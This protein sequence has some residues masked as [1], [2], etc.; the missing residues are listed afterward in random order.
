[1]T[2]KLCTRKACVSAASRTKP[3][4]RQA[5][6]IQ[7]PRVSEELLQSLYARQGPF[8]QLQED[9]WLHLIRISASN[10]RLVTEYEYHDSPDLGH[11]R[12]HKSIVAL[13]EK[14]PINYH[15][16]R[17][18]YDLLDKLDFQQVH[19]AERIDHV[20]ERWAQLELSKD[21]ERFAGG[22]FTELSIRDEFRC[23]IAALYGR[24]YKDK[25]FVILG[26][27]DADDVTLRCAYYA[28]GDLGPKD[29]DAGYKRDA[30]VFVFAATLNGKVH[31]SADL[32]RMMEEE[33]LNGS[34]AKRWLKYD[35]QMRKKWPNHVPPISQDI[36]IETESNPPDDT[37]SAIAELHKSLTALTKRVTEMRQLMIV[38]AIILAFLIYFHAR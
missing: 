5:A 27:R 38:V 25:Q 22:Y 31:Q 7:N 19:A 34:T 15:S 20:L 17:V 11:Y 26:D 23:L 24:T 3:P 6:F 14:A 13:L 18:L 16:L 29:M 35:Q 2:P 1:M 12:I 32:R 37:T 30:S 28:N 10:A 8:G 33:Y 36:R 4:H 9:R 21:D